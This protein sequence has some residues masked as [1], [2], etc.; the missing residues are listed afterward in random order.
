MKTISEKAKIHET[1]KISNFTIVEAN[2]EIGENCEIGS[3]VLICEGT[4]L[5]KNVQVFHGAVI[6]NKSQDLKSKNELS[7]VEIGDFTTIR[8]YV[9]INRASEKNGVTKIGKNCLLMAY[10][11]VA[12]DCKIGNNVILANCV[13]LAGYVEI[14]DFAG[15]GGI[16]PV[17]QFVK[18]GKFAF[19]GGGYRVS[20]DVPPYVLA[21]EE[22]LRFCGLNSVGLKRNGFS[23]S[24]LT[25]IKR[26][27]KILYR[28]DLNIS[29]AAEILS[30]EKQNSREKT[31]ILNF[32]R[33]SKRGL[34]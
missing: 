2:C 6:G 4:K 8:E 33:N 24:Q 17:H 30:D 15:I 26:V 1:A 34:I 28:L 20:K 25:E 13:Q 19:V 5:G 29:Q 14:D 12:H 11:H 23:Q 16:V 31:E 9:T 32:I 22:P 18:I 27:Y 10:V 7:F 3:N 21:G